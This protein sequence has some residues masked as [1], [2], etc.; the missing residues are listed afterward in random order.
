M[1][2]EVAERR[3]KLK[4][5]ACDNQG[6]Y[7]GSDSIRCFMVVDLEQGQPLLEYKCASSDRRNFAGEA[8]Q[9]ATGFGKQQQLITE[10]A[11]TGM[12]FAETDDDMA[13]I[14]FVAPDYPERVAKTIVDRHARGV[15]AM[16]N[17]GTFAP[18]EGTK[19]SAGCKKAY[20]SLCEQLATEFDRTSTHGQAATIQKEVNELA[21]TVASKALIAHHD[22]LE[23]LDMMAAKGAAIASVSP[24]FNK[25]AQSKKKKKWKLGGGGGG[26]R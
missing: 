22:Q 6:S 5:R 23:S 10:Q 4:E 26:N 14:C 2:C 21:A 7:G 20:K 15:E 3:Q 11:R 8:G 24:M 1:Q 17:D 25:H 16:Q 18:Q 13:Y 9:K 19:Q 12:I